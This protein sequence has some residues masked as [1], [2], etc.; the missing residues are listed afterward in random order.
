MKFQIRLVAINKQLEYNLEHFRWL[1]GG[2]TIG[3]LLLVLDIGAK[4]LMSEKMTLNMGILFLGYSA[5]IIISNHFFLRRLRRCMD[6]YNEQIRGLL[7]KLGK[8]DKNG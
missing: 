6:H 7:T 5:I 3:G 4:I 8:E 2:I 1:I